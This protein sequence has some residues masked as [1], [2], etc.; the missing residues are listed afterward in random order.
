MR[1]WQSYT[2]VRSSSRYF[3]CGSHTKALIA[4]KNPSWELACMT[5]NAVLQLR[6]AWVPLSLEE[7]GIAARTSADVVTGAESEE[8]LNGIRPRQYAASSL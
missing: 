4:G 1:A 2:H 7:E 3:V 6:S 5:R 8:L